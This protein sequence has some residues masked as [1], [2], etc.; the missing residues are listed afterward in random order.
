MPS[1]LARRDKLNQKK[2]YGVKVY[3]INLSDSDKF[4]AFSG[5][6]LPKRG[7]VV[8]YDE[9][10]YSDWNASESAANLSN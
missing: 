8:L 7:M 10:Y 1:K 3:Y 2:T 5:K 4:C 6:K 9:K